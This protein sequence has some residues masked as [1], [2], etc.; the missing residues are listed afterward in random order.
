M[1][2]TQLTDQTLDELTYRDSVSDDLPQMTVFTHGLGGSGAHF[3]SKNSD[4]KGFDYEEGSMIEQLRD[5]IEASGEEALVISVSTGYSVYNSLGMAQT[6]GESRSV[7]AGDE[8]INA[9]S[10][11]AVN[12]DGAAT[13]RASYVNYKPDKKVD[14]I[15]E[16]SGKEEYV[17]SNKDD[18]TV[19]AFGIENIPIKKIEGD[20]TRKAKI[21]NSF[22]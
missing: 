22:V 2:Y 13:F 15:T 3:S 8:N 11:Q 10:A 16:N 5:Q 6:I 20:G 18:K 21:C 9:L 17:I 19:D 7:H 12:D 1:D 14:Q 4:G